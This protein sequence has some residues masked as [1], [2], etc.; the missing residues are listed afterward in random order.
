VTIGAKRLENPITGTWERAGN[1]VSI[2]VK[3]TSGVRPAS[4]TGT[5]S[6]GGG[7]GSWTDGK[8]AGGDWS[9]GG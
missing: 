7:S 4:Y 5:I 8:R 3:E 6:A 2:T 9:V 1:G